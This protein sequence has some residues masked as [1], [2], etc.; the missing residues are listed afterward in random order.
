MKV[1]DIKNKKVGRKV[2]DIKNK[3]FG[4]L[5][6]VKFIGTNKNRG[7]LWLCKCDCGNTKIISR[8]SLQSG[9][10]KSCGCLKKD[11]SK[12][13]SKNI[14]GRKY[15]RL[16]IINIMGKDKWNHIIFSCQCDC[17]NKITCL[18]E[19]LRSKNTTSCGCYRT[20]YK[21]KSW[22]GS[23]NPQFNPLLTETERLNGRT[24]NENYHWVKKIFERD[25]YI[26]KKC[27]IKSGC[28][29]KISLHAHHIDGYNWCKERRFDLNNGITLCNKCHYNF[30]KKYGKGNNTKNQ[31]KE[32][33]KT[34]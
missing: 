10:A 12:N 9:K 24:K 8:G 1:K 25:H 4:R 18:A 31:F 17:G 6:V 20:E 2:I 29:Y 34:Q 15:G 7:A 16:T 5:L 23:R 27:G 14:I 33:L 26:C 11:W 22:E 32:F 19:S 30:H 13:A 28:G 21:V 3:R